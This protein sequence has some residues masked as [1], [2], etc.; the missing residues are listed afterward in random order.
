MAKYTDIPAFKEEYK[1]YYKLAQAYTDDQLAETGCK[2]HKKYVRPK[3][4]NC[5]AV[6]KHK[7]WCNTE[8]RTRVPFG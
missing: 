8:L 4:S 7:S 6:C 5:K 1:S 3:C 2:R